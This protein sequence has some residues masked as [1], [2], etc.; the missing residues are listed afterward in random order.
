MKIFF[1]M[2]GT[3]AKFNDDKHL[4]I[5]HEKGVFRNLKPYALAEYVNTLASKQDNIYILSACVLSPYC[6]TEKIE[7]CKQYLP[8]IPL[9]HIILVDVGTNKAQAVDNIVGNEQALLVDDYSR[10]IYEWENHKNS[11]KAIKFCNGHNN[12][13]NKNYTHKFKTIKQFNNFL[14]TII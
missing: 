11:Y 5:M 6:R 13:T 7:W 2:D 12:K 4:P 8:N 14:W 1:D 3:L 10:N 9:D